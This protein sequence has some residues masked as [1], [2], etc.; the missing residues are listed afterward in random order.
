MEKENDTGYYQTIVGYTQGDSN[1]GCA[2]FG[3]PLY[4]QKGENAKRKLFMII[5]QFWK[6]LFINN[7]CSKDGFVLFYSNKRKQL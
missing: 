2:C 1:S 3:I 6:V 7:L 4:F 5:K